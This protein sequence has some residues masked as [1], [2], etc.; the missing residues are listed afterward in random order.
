VRKLA[1]MHDII[2]K[3]GL[4]FDGTGAPGGV[5]HLGIR[6]GLVAEVSATPLDETGCPHVIDASE[7][8]VMPGFVDMHTHYDAELV[9]APALH[10]SVRNGVTTVMVGSCSI[11][12]VLSDAEDCSD[13]FTR[14]ESVPRDF[15]L[16]L[17]RK[18]KT[19]RTPAE[20][21]NFLRQHPLGPNVASFLGHSDLR[22]AV[23]GLDR[24]VDSR[25]RPTETEMQRMESLLHEALDAGLM[26][27][28]TMTNPWD[29]LDGDRQRSKSLPSTYA[30]WREYRRLTAL[31]R[32]RGAIHQSAPNLVTKVNLVLFLADS[33][34]WFRKRLKTTIIT[35]MDL[36]ADP[37]LAKVLGPVTR[38]INRLGADFRWQT[39]PAPFET[40]ADGVEFV[41]FEEFPAGQAALHLIDELKRNTLFQDPAYRRQ[42]RANVEKKFGPRVWHRDLDDAWIVDC[43][44]EALVGRSVGE[45]ARARKEN[46]AD[47]FLDL[48]IAHGKRLRWRT[49]IANHNPAVVE[50]LVNEPSTLIGFADS[51]AHIRNMAFYN[52]GLRLLKLVRD[53]ELRGEPFM[54]VERAVW[55]LSRELA[56]WFNVDAGRLQVGDRADVVIIDPAKLDESLTQYREAQIAQF[57]GLLRIVNDGNA[58]DTTII[59]GRVAWHQGK[60]ANALGRERVFG[61]YLPARNLPRTYGTSVDLPSEGQPKPV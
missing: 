17:L 48:L 50:K 38:F 25:V 11:S 47:V 5:R 41:V 14:V 24:A 19:W 37:L 52:F 45:V 31:L 4:F 16:P 20:Y 21:V 3:N 15:V 43:P 40:F 49:V 34:G 44:D 26:G 39:L 6:G 46:P 32:Q 60:F 33:L 13:L 61:E 56:D 9:A 55:R 18:A 58:V 1:G 30:T 57:E 12:M 42:F 2:I 8:W 36:K 27:L 59:G 54:P 22:V 51:G 35:L 28:S 7:R 10:E 29:K 53:A 23:M